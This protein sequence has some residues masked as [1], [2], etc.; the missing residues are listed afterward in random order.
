MKTRL[1]KEKIK[2]SI[3][4]QM[5]QWLKSKSHREVEHEK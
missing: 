4:I 3:W 2:F 1:T 5:N